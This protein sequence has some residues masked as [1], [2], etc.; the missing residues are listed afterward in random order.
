MSGKRDSHLQK[1]YG[2]KT[3]LAMKTY[4]VVI[5][6]VLFGCTPI[7]EVAEKTIALGDADVEYVKVVQ[8]DDGTWTFV[9]TV[10]HADTGW[11]DYADG[12][13]VVVHGVVAKKESD[14]FTRVITHPHVNEQPF[15][16]SQSGLVVND[17]EVVVRAHDSVDGFGGKEV[18]VD[19]RKKKGGNYEV[20]RKP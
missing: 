6:I 14:A 19:L 16:R 1:G 3:D 2:R 15:T 7:P 17:E 12:W 10:R 9:V 11:D 13:D 8:H 4:L 5:L 20:E 18:V